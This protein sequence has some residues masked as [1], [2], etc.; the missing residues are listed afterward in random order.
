MKWVAI[1]VMLAVFLNLAI[2][3]GQFLYVVGNP[4]DDMKSSPG[5]VNQRGDIAEA[6]VQACTLIG[7]VENYYVTLQIHIYPRL[8]PKKILVGYSPVGDHDP[9]LRWID[10]NTLSVDLG[11]VSWISSRPDRVGNIRILYRNVMAD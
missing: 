10:D 2:F 3:A 8:Y 6:R 1:T 11:K 4:C 7:T 9:I 5:A